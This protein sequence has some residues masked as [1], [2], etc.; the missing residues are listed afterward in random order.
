MDGVA[1]HLEKYFSVSGFRFCFPGGVFF[2]QLFNKINERTKKAS[3]LN[4][5]SAL[6]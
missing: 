5:D 6:K 2:A 4:S 3:K 1:P